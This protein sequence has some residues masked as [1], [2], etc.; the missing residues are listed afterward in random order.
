MQRKR[1]K[2]YLAGGIY[3]YRGKGQGARG[4]GQG[5]RGKGQRAK[6]KGQRVKGLGY[7]AWSGITSLI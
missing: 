6:G 4:K 7:G 5:A 3:T 2:T 1:L